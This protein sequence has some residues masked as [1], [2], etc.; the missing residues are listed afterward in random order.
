MRAQGRPGGRC[1]A[2]PTGR[3]RPRCLESQPELP[4]GG[5]GPGPA[6]ERSLLVLTDRS[7]PGTVG[8]ARG[9]Q[10]CGCLPPG[11]RPVAPELCGTRAASVLTLC[12]EGALAPGERRP[13]ELRASLVS[14][15]PLISGALPR[16]PEAPPY[17]PTGPCAPAA[18]CSSSPGSIRA[19]RP[20]G[21][22]CQDVA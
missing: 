15:V 6:L 7:L 3:S 22:L 5:H 12:G 10:R 14:T 21:S 2:W 11:P 16:F 1:R 8:S 19:G 9:E 18:V 17:P 13:H 4:R 20:G